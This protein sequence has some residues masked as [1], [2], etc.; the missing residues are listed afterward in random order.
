MWKPS[1]GLMPCLHSVSTLLHWLSVWL[2]AYHRSLTPPSKQ[3]CKCLHTETFPRLWA[4][5]ELDILNPSKP[6]YL[7]E[8][9][10]GLYSH[11]LR[12]YLESRNFFTE[13]R[14]IKYHHL[15]CL[16]VCLS[17]YISISQSL[18]GFQS[19]TNK[20]FKG[21]LW[22]ARDKTQRWASSLNHG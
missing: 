21:P 12:C 2:L 15:S 9:C 22:R 4:S 19:L 14:M 20:L 10:L 11:C 7:D 5:N 13:A 18:L 1:I 6:S 3:S 17:V 16:S 8:A